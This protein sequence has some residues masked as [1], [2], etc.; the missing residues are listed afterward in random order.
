MNMPIMD[1]PETVKNILKLDEEGIL[2]RK[3]IKI[4]ALSAIT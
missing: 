3:V 4:I 2:N 1:G